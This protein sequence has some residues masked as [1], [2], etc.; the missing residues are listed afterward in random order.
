[1]MHCM[2]VCLAVKCRLCVYVI[3]QLALQCEA[4]DQLM[5]T[6]AN[7]GS[8][9]DF[10]TDRVSRQAVIL[11]THTLLCF[12]MPSLSVAP[13]IRIRDQAAENLKIGES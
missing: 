8:H 5:M 13:D 3:E 11:N 4:E 6:A 7:E 9:A 1:M 12:R 10:E 2:F